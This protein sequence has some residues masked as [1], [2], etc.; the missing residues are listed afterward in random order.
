MR[1][2]AAPNVVAVVGDAD[3]LRYTG[4]AGAQGP[5]MPQAVDGDTVYRIMSMTKMVVTVAALQLMEQGKLNLDAP[6]ADYYP[7]FAQRKVLTGFDGD[8]PLLRAPTRQVTVQQLITHTAGLSYSFFNQ[9][10]L[11]WE[12][13]TN[14]VGILSGETELLQSPLMFDPGDRFEYGLN[15]DV[16]AVVISN[17]TGKKLD[18]HLADAIL[19]PLGMRSTSYHKRDVDESKITPI[20]ARGPDGKWVDTGVDYAQNPA[21]IPGGHGLCSTPNDYM[22]FQRALLRGGE[23]DGARILQQKTVDAAFSNQ[24]GALEFPPTIST[25]NPTLTCDFS[26]GPGL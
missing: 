1:N 2:G 3:G 25:A 16:L 12:Q 8:R 17:I 11:K 5:G 10:L 23:L 18:V 4:A 26:A 9:D 7:D 19:K 20:Q 24:I 6:V 14:Y 15:I 22:R 13:V 21:L